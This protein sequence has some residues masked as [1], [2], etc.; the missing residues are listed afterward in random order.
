MHE[1]KTI[2]IFLTI[3]IKCTNLS[4]FRM[5]NQYKRIHTYSLVSLVSLFNGISRFPD[6]L[7]PKSSLLKKGDANIWLIAGRIREFKPFPK[8]LIRKWT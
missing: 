1:F 6:Y 3:S 4:N 2:N 5:Q 7:I 8:V